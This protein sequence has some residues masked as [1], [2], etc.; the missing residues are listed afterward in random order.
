MV[1]HPEEAAVTLREGMLADHR[2]IEGLLTRVVVA[3]EAVDPARAVAEWAELDRALTAHLD[4]EDRHIIPTLF[5]SRPRDA[6][7]LLQ[8][9]RHVR[10][11]ALELGNAIRKNTLSPWTVRGFLDELSAHVRRETEVLYDFAD[12]EVAEADRSAALLA[13][14]PRPLSPATQPGTASRKS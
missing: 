3:L 11:R 13:V 6:Q 8:E 7:S 9:H 12:E 10:N 1:A 4:A 5:A 2:R 14:A